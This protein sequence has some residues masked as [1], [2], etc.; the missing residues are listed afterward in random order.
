MADEYGTAERPAL[1]TLATHG[2]D[3]IGRKRDK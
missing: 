3:V 2:R 1:E